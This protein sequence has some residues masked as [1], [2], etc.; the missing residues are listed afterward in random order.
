MIDEPRIVQSGARVTAI[1]RLTIP[2]PE[3]QAVMGPAIG[4]LMST[5]AAQGIAP[6]GL[7]Y[8]HHLT[9]QP[10]TFDFELG[11]PVSAPVSAGIERGP[12][13]LAD[14]AQPPPG[15][16]GQRARSLPAPPRSR[17]GAYSTRPARRS[18]IPPDR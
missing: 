17:P 6:A 11:V 3:I 16:L 1:I 5:V 14:R 4:E 2:R 8:S 12:R 18:R 10:D 7:L 9:M 15:Q 13:Q